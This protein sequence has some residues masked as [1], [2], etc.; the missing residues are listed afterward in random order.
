MYN[1]VT[2][3]HYIQTNSNT[4]RIKYIHQLDFSDVPLSVFSE[5]H[6]QNGSR[7]MTDTGMHNFLI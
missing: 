3:L 4:Y 5:T 2:I 6:I 7:Q 1:F